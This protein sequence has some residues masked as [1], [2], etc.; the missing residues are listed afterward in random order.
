MKIKRSCL[1]TLVVV[2]VLITVG[3]A[4]GSAFAY[5]VGVQ[6]LALDQPYRAQALE[7]SVWYPSDIESAGEPFGENKIFNGVR[8]NRDAPIAQG[9][10]PTVIMSHGGLRSAPHLGGWISGY[11][12]EKGFIVIVPRS[13]I[14]KAPPEQAINEI[15]LRPLDLSMA[16]DFVIGQSTLS[17]SVDLQAIAALG[18]YLGGTASLMLSGVEIDWKKYQAACDTA[19]KSIDCRWFM[20]QGISPQHVEIPQTVKSFRH[21]LVQTSIAID[22]EYSSAVVTNNQSVYSQV[23]ILNLDALGATS[24]G[25]EAAHLRDAI[26]GLN[27]QRLS[28]ASQ[29]SGFNLC[30]AG[31]AELLSRAGEGEE[32]LCTEKPGQTREAIQAELSGLIETKLRNAFARR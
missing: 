18:F 30:K 27:Y 1:N 17:D 12:A 29:Y 25:L 4:S 6:I 22:P 3:M 31:A 24:P 14:T 13:S 19:P 9:T 16:L 11:L 23:H 32:I 7:V 10:F 8:A 15:W 21:S 2:Y 20:K 28:N 5:Q 26:S